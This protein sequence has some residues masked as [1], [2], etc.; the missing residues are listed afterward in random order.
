MGAT[1]TP[2]WTGDVTEFIVTSRLPKVR[3]PS[4]VYLVR[5]EDVESPTVPERTVKFA[6]S[7]L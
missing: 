7:D 2:A 3:L 4:I 5:P 1:P 6:V